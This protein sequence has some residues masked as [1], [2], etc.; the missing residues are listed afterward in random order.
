M[1]RFAAPIGTAKRNTAAKRKTM[2]RFARPPFTFWVICR[3]IFITFCVNLLRFA[4]SSY[5]LGNVTFFGPTIQAWSP[6][7]RKD[8]DMLEQIQRR[9]QKRTKKKKIHFNR[10]L[11]RAS[12]TPSAMIIPVIATRA[13]LRLVRPMNLLCH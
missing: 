5:V 4:L 6:Y 12:I 1:L 3:K 13:L 8:I 11:F 10:C 7:L 2:L 9:A